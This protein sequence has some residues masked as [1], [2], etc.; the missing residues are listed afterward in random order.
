MSIQPATA[1]PA[2]LPVGLGLGRGYW[3]TTLLAY[4]YLFPAILILGSFHFF[5]IFYAFYVSL[6]NWGLVNRGFVGLDNYAQALASP[7]LW[8]SVL[9]TFSYAL[10][11][12]PVTLVLSM[13]CAYF[14]FKN[15][16]GLAIC[17]T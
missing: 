9:V 5:P 8:N 17:R 10:G 2:S 11:T 6:N 1:A 7:D 12:V 13:L 14:L 3:R 4:A 16:M 15:V